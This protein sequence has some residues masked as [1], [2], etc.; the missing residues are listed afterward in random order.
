MQFVLLD[1]LAQLVHPHYNV[2]FV[3]SQMLLQSVNINASMTVL[4]KEPPSVLNLKR[5][6]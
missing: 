5:V 4:P 3:R 1:L 2:S 6:I